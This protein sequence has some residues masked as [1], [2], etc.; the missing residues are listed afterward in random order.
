MK[1]QNIS[2]MQIVDSTVWG[3]VEQYVYDMSVELKKRGIKTFILTDKHNTLLIN[4]YQEVA[5]VITY[6]LAIDRGYARIFSLGKLIKHAHIKAINVHGG[7]HIFLA[8]LLKAVSGSKI[9]FYKHNVLKAKHDIYHKW[10]QNRVDA[11]ICVSKTVYDLQVD[12]K[13]TEKFHIIYNGINPSRFPSTQSKEAT[14]DFIVGFSGRVTND[15]G[16]FELL[17]AIKLLN[18]HTNST[19]IKLIVCGQIQ[20]PIGLENHITDNNLK[21]YVTLLGHQKNLDSFYHSIDCLVAPSKTA[22]S[23]GLVICEAMYCQVPIIAS[24]TGAQEEIITNGKDGLLIKDITPEIIAKNIQW[25]IDHPKERITIAKKGQQ[26][27][28]DKFTINKMVDSILN[29][30]K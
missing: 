17:D 18:A 30:I 15:K 16:I 11:F 9:L 3:G 4:R 22:E 6:N 12:S 14:K 23:F 27:V 13:D 10:V 28:I 20:D 29:L 8:I 25:L 21:E 5:T 24:S 26:R 19:S 1:S 7:K 2:V